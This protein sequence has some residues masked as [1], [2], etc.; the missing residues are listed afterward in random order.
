MVSKSNNSI[1]EESI[2]RKNKYVSSFKELEIA[3]AIPV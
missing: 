3:L 2:F 1:G